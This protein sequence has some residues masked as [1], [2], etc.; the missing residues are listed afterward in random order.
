M[1]RAVT[2]HALCAFMVWTATFLAFSFYLWLHTRMI[3]QGPICCTASWYNGG[4]Y[5]DRRRP[6]SLEC[7]IGLSACHLFNDA[8]GICNCIMSN[9]KTVNRELETLCKSSG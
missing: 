1:S 6:H 5:F 7:S 3:L 8:L 4:H 2:L 9:D